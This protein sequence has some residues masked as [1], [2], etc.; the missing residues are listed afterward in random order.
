[1]RTGLEQFQVR[2]SACVKLVLRLYLMVFG[3][4]VAGGV[5]YRDGAP[6]L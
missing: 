4:A 5:S 6:G 2:D 3:M 1:M